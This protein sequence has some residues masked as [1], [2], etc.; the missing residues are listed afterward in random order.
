MKFGYKGAVWGVWGAL[1]GGGGRDEGRIAGLI[2]VGL[3]GIT[4]HILLALVATL[5]V[6][7]VSEG[8]GGCV[9]AVAVGGESTLP[10]AHSLHGRARHLGPIPWFF[11]D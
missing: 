10:A 3:R 5:T 1:E 7:A 6:K 11:G 2:C 9:E 8:V 4:A